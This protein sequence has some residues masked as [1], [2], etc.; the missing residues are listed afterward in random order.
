MGMNNPKEM[1]F[2]D[3]YTTRFCASGAP[4][5]V[6]IEYKKD[7]VAIDLGLHL[8]AG[9][10]MSNSRVWFQLKGVHAALPLKKFKRLNHAICKKISIKHLRAWYQTP[11]V[12]Y[13][14]LYVESADLFLAEDVKTIVARQWG[15]E[16]LNEA[17]FKPRKKNVAVKIST[18][19]PVDDVFWRSLRRRQ[20]MRTDGQKFRGH[21]LDHDLDPYRTT[22]E[23]MEPT[24]FT[25]IVHDLLAEHG[26]KRRELLDAA[27]LFPD[28]PAGNIASLEL[29]VLHEKF[30]IV[31][32]ITTELIPDEE[33]DEPS[34]GESE[35]AY[36]P[37]AVLIHSA[38]ERVPSIA[39]LRAV[40][41]KLAAQKIKRLLVQVNAPLLNPVTSLG[42]YTQNLGGFGVRCRP[43]HLEDLS[44]K[45]LITTNTYRRFRDRVSYFGRRL[46][47]K[48]KGAAVHSLPWGRPSDSAPL[49]KG[50]QKSNAI[51]RRGEAL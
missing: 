6:T 45:F 41:E 17:M 32:Q 22:L 25:D 3:I 15:D 2:E 16:V 10:E 36:G 19:A 14:V 5:G 24:L 48:N 47:K 44:F 27:A 1:E 49:S 50:S 51:R 31:H 28:A 13:L 42:A 23:Q 34:E 26:Y 11:E 43:Q 12:V 8:R 35:M 37:C 46:W 38:V 30:E 18:S 21:S 4:Y 29:G 20:S 9:D 39:G 33:D 40:G 7:V